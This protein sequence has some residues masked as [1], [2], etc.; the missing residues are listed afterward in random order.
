[1]Y[2]I[3]VTQNP[4]G[5][6]PIIITVLATACAVRSAECGLRSSWCQVVC[7]SRPRSPSAPRADPVRSSRGW[8]VSRKGCSQGRRRLERRYSR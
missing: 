4:A 5:A 8:S 2:I 6:A 1:M 3:T 7:L